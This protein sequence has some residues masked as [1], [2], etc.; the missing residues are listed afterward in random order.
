MKQFMG[1]VKELESLMPLRMQLMGERQT[2][3]L[4][5]EESRGGVKREARRE[6][7][8]PKY[9]CVNGSQGYSS[10]ARHSTTCP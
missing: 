8:E 6:Q 10:S 5:R 3:K 7:S 2:S 9:V 4:V 1:F